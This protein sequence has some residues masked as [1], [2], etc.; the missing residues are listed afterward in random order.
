MTGSGF[1][2]YRVRG[3]CKASGLSRAIGGVQASGRHAAGIPQRL[4]VPL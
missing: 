4:H 1:R 3:V 2:V